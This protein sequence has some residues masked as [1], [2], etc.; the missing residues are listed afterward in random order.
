MQG[1]IYC[2]GHRKRAA[3]SYQSSISTTG[4]QLR[5]AQHVSNACATRRAGS[6]SVA[7]AIGKGMHKRPLQMD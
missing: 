7:V 2:V 1:K 6:A 4:T 5:P 3:K